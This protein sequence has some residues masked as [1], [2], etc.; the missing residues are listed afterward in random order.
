MGA[1]EVFG[2]IAAFGCAVLVVSLVLLVVK[3]LFD[4]LG[5]QHRAKLIDL[6]DRAARKVIERESYKEMLAKSSSTSILGGDR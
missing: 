3:A 1:W 5:E 6:E 2:W 4:S